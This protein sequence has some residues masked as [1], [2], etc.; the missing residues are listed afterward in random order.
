MNAH[1]G[2]PVLLGQFRGG[3]DLAGP[4]VFSRRLK[5]WRLLERSI[6]E[7][8]RNGTYVPNTGVEMRCGSERVVAMMANLNF[9]SLRQGWLSTVMIRLISHYTI[10]GID[11]IRPLGLT[12]IAR[13]PGGAG[14]GGPVRTGASAPRSPTRIQWAVTF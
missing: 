3:F 7:F 4:A 10:V 2:F 9:M 5:P 11:A 6:L 12:L 13:A 8:L 1:R 14:P